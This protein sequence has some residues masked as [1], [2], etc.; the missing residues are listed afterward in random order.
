MFR[1]F[2]R[3]LKCTDGGEAGWKTRVNEFTREKLPPYFRLKKKKYVY[4]VQIG[5]PNF[6]GS[7]KLPKRGKN[8]VPFHIFLMKMVLF[9][10]LEKYRLLDLKFSRFAW[11]FD[12]SFPHFSIRLP[13]VSRTIT[14]ARW[15]SLSPAERACLNV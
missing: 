10:D 15:R 14:H 9:P 6:E 2:K 13:F 5:V 3:L 7:E 11:H 8:K 12:F 1:R 4:Y